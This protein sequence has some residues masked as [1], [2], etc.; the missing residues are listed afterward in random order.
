MPLERTTLV[1]TEKELASKNKLQNIYEE[2]ATNWDFEGNL[3][4]GQDLRN[5]ERI[6]EIICGNVFVETWEGILEVAN[7]EILHLVS[8]VLMF[9]FQVQWLGLPGKFSC[10][11]PCYPVSFPRVFLHGRP[12]VNTQQVK[13]V[14]N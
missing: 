13:L 2:P 3:I 6:H 11:S 14:N 1:G 9:Q 10:L 4:N 5:T 12:L 7:F 8:Y